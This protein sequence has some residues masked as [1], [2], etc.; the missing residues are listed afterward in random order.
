MRTT[1]Q[2]KKSS[3]PK[4]AQS[5]SPIQKKKLLKFVDKL[6]RTDKS[7]EGISFKNIKK[8]K[9]SSD[10]IPEFQREIEKR[11]Q[12]AETNY[13]YRF[14]R[15]LTEREPN[16]KDS[17]NSLENVRE[18]DLHT[19]NFKEKT[20]KLKLETLLDNNYKK[21]MLQLVPNSCRLV[22]ASTEPQENPLLGFNWNKSNRAQTPTDRITLIN[23]KP[24]N[25]LESLN[26][27]PIVYK[28]VKSPNYATQRNSARADSNMKLKFKEEEIQEKSVEKN[29]NPYRPKTLL[30]DFSPSNSLNAY[31]KGFFHSIKGQTSTRSNNQNTIKV[32]ELIEDGSLPAYTLKTQAKSQNTKSCKDLKS[33]AYKMF[34]PPTEENESNSNLRAVTKQKTREPKS[35]RSTINLKESIR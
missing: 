8:E 29:N 16:S 5:Q 33:T 11:F 32:S 2:A 31:Q 35:G 25:L 9:N 6:S 13:G 28:I 34:R 24:P 22:T 15:K 7:V 30:R 12:T 14:P 21:E 23:K 19:Q 20:L 18:Y 3:H 26:E 17:D 10:E 1:H 27:D 4:P